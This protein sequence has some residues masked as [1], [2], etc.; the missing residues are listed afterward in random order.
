[1]IINWTKNIRL[2]RGKRSFWPF[3]PEFGLK[4]CALNLVKTPIERSLDS[5]LK[6]KLKNAAVLFFFNCNWKIHSK[7]LWDI[8]NLAH[9]SMAGQELTKFC[10]I[11]PERRRRKIGLECIYL[12][13][14]AEISSFYIKINFSP[15]KKVWKNYQTMQKNFNSDFKPLIR[16]YL[17]KIFAFDSNQGSDLN[18]FWRKPFTEEVTFTYGESVW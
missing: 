11:F 1:M 3:N 12:L 4:I 2:K 7:E 14:W 15:A 8:K 17:D 10:E 9:P 16:F 5:D 13:F 6:L 18:F